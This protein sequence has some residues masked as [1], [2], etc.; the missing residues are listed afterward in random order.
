MK[1]KTKK[2]SRQRFRVI[3]MSPLANGKQIK[4]FIDRTRYFEAIVI[5][6]CDQ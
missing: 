2:T 6:Y 4:I 5:A 1:K 3:S